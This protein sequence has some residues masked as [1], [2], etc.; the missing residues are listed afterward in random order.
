MIKGPPE[1]PGFNGVSVWRYSP[2]EYICL[3]VAE[4]IPCV[5][6]NSSPSGFPIAITFC[7][8]LILSESPNGNDG[9]FLIAPDQMK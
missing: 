6:E 8:I 7:P 9:V 4:T 2:L 1:F 5:T 3:S